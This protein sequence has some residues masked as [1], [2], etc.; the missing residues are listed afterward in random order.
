MA[1]TPDRDQQ[2]EAPTDKRRRDAADK[3]DRLRSRELGILMGTGLG[4]LALLLALRQGDWGM[5]RVLR[6]SFQAVADPDRIAT[7]E[8]AFAVA[9]VILF[10][11]ALVAV[12]AV[13][14][15]W[16]A[17]LTGGVSFS[18]SAVAP[19]FSRLSPFKAR[20][21][22]APARM[23]VDLLRTLFRLCAVLLAGGGT[24][25]HLHRDLIGSA[26]HDW[27]ARLAQGWS[28]L[29]AVVMASLF[30]LALA[31]LIDLPLD[32]WRR[33]QRLRMSRQDMRD[34]MKQ[35]EGSP[36][37]RA[38]I[39][40]R[41]REAVRRSVAPAVAS[42]TAVIVNPTHFAVALRYDPARDAAPVLIAKG[43]GVIAQAIRDLAQDGGK[44]L[45]RAPELA[46]ALYFGGRV[47]QMIPVDLY[48]AAATVLAFIARSGRKGMLEAEAVD[49]PPH[50]RFDSEGRRG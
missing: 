47:G 48:L 30:G 28:F 49:V 39:R 7:G 22:M 3:G 31:L 12:V 15:M 29:M 24:A 19:D 16:A 40:R 5:A 36:D 44:P 32:W 4:L 11:L 42:A 35:S 46:R 41:Q 37:V 27:G 34:E 18:L 23:I 50:L 8:I 26:G 14:S 6:L 9:W 20:G 45:V 43:R 10:G 17:I 21:G 1:E 38:A 13:G 25:V 33:E 2:T